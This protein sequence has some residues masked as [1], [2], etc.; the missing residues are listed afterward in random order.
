MYH[1]SSRV[2]ENNEEMF[3][4]VSSAYE[5]IT[6]P[7]D[8]EFEYEPEPEY[9]HSAVEATPFRAGTQAKSAPSSTKATTAEQENRLLATVLAAQSILGL[10][11]S[12]LPA[13]AKER[14]LAAVM[15]KIEA[16]GKEINAPKNRFIVEDLM[17]QVELIE[18]CYILLANLYNN[19]AKESTLRECANN[20]IKLAPKL[21]DSFIPKLSTN[22]GA[23]P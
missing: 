16:L 20:I 18:Q 23:A 10:S 22:D 12:E 2:G 13:E 17:N 9:T 7:E 1:P 15:K 3:K 14:K 21:V 19:T 11:E 5:K 8:S 6:N 4:K